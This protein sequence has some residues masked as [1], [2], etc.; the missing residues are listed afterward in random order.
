MTTLVV[1]LLCALFVIG[2]PVGFALIIAVIPYF[3]TVGSI[4]IIASDSIG[5]K[6]FSRNLTRFWENW[7]L[8]L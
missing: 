4:P 1:V 8:A 6:G 3:A 2:I 7:P 5:A